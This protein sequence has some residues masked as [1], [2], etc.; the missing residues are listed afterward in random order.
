VTIDISSAGGQIMGRR[1]M[2]EDAFLIMYPDLTG[3]PVAPTLLMVADGIGGQ[4]GGQVASRMAVSAFAEEMAALRLAEAPIAVEPAPDQNQDVD[5]L[6]DFGDFFD[7]VNVSNKA[8]QHPPASVHLSK[9]IR[10]ALL[11]ALA[12]ANQ[13]MAEAKERNPNLGPMGSTFVAALA[14]DGKLWWISVGDSH[15]YL[16]RQS[17]LERNWTSRPKWE[18]SS[19]RFQLGNA[20]GLPAPWRVRILLAWIVPSYRW[21]SKRAISLCSPVMD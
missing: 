5:F 10:A 1:A 3:L 8:A 6:L 7:N 17:K 12:R 18:K 21:N 16:I 13:G 19:R 14:C 20:S 2:Q 11:N 4:A 9:Q 15:L